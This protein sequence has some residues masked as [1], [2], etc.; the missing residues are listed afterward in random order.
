M[1][2]MNG[3]DLAQELKALQPDLKVLFMSGYTDDVIA[4]HGLINRDLNFI[5]KP[6]TQKG[7]AE[8]IRE[9]LDK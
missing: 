4:D 6:F 2:E 1:P 8:K 7:L 9:V 5:E 3:K